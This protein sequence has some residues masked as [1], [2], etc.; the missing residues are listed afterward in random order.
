M[1]DLNMAPK[2]VA[3]EVKL[4]IIRKYYGE[5]RIDV[6]D[7]EVDYVNDVRCITWE[8]NMPA[9]VFTRAQECLVTSSKVLLPKNLV[10]VIFDY[11]YG[12]F[13]SLIFISFL[14]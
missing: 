11:A 2:E 3:K 6:E 5:D 8:E 10:N 9:G 12:I 13:F 4:K 1:K 7:L 14:N